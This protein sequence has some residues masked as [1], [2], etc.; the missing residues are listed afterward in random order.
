MNEVDIF[1]DNI[2]LKHSMEGR[3]P[4]V[5]RFV[6]VSLCVCVCW[7]GNLLY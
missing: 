1:T 2:D 6:C 5:E 3:M 7:G 4:G